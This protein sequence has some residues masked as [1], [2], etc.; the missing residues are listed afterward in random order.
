MASPVELRL[1][2]AEEVVA[3]HEQHMVVDFP[4]DE[5]KPLSLLQTLIA[6]GVN[7]MWVCEH[8]GAFVGYA[9]LAV[10]ENPDFVLLDYLA[11]EASQRDR[12]WGSAIL[13]A[14]S[15]RLPGRTILIESEHADPA[16]D[17]YEEQLRRLAFYERCGAEYS[18]A[19]SLLFGVDY[20]LMQLG[21]ILPTADAEREYMSLYKRMLPPEWYEKNVKIL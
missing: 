1:A 3:I 14:L 13:R 17:T 21:R 19:R 8:E 16:A 7:S 9:V 2:S 20:E 4:P 11:V 18:G 15:D 10:A 12:G 5:L 6:E